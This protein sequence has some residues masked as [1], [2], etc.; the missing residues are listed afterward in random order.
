MSLPWPTKDAAGK[1]IE[2]PWTGGPHAALKLADGSTSVCRPPNDACATDV[3]DNIRSGIDFGTAGGADWD[4]YAVGPGTL[5]YK[6][7]FGTTGFGFGAVTQHGDLFVLYGH[8]DQGSLAA[9]PEIGKPVDHSTRLGTTSCTGM[10]PDECAR[11]LHLE[12][13]KG[14]TVANGTVSN[15]GTNEPWNGRTIGG[16]TIKVGTLNYDGTASASACIPDTIAAKVAGPAVYDASTCGGA[17]VV[18]APPPKP[19]LDAGP[20]RW[21]SAGRLPYPASQPHAAL[22][23]DGRVLIVGADNICTPGGAWDEAKLAQVFNPATGKVTKTRSL[24]NPRDSFAIATLADGRVLVAGGLNASEIGKSS[25]RIWNPKT[26]AWSEA[27]LMH[28]A[29]IG[30]IGAALPGGKVLV[31][32]GTD[33]DGN[34]LRSAEVYDP[35]R[36][37]WT[38]T[39]TLPRGGS[40]RVA[41]PLV[42]GRVLALAEG[43]S[44]TST[45]SL[46]AAAIYSPAT[47]T[48]SSIGSLDKLHG[49]LPAVVPLADGGAL[50]IGG[51]NANERSVR[52][53]ERLDP[54]SGKWRTVGSLRTA[55]DGA[56]AALLDDGRVLVAGGFS[57]DTW[58]SNRKPLVSAEVFDPAKNVFGRASDMPKPRNRGVAVL[59]TDGSVLVAGGDIGM[60]GEPS[61]PWCPDLVEAAVRWVP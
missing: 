49:H 38:T 27:A 18:S 58:A 1:P 36:D 9:A 29:R 31:A 41:V 37:R 8:M 46:E 3:P 20:G 52:S 54:R 59:L 21:V 17:A 26:G 6:G 13:R 33:N 50:V 61:T 47:G 40:W 55:R 56:V 5:V 39:G 44:D 14:L 7:S 4:V 10:K 57:G 19:G 24:E 28:Q 60:Q 22:A 48:W 45:P 16:W 53:V 15:L 34:P 35:G 2:H 30:P 42:D 11:H 12:L 25:V 23:G 43:A 51:A 32:G